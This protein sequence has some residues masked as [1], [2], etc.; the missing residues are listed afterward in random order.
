MTE[1][2]AQVSRTVNAP[3]D[4]VWDALTDPRKVGALFMGST[5]RTDF[6]KGSPITFKGEFKGKP[7]EDKGEILSVDECRRLSFSHYSGMS[8]APDAPENYHVV[9]FDLRPEGEATRVTLTQSNL[10]GGVRQADI[11]H[12]ADYEKTWSAV[13]DGLD[14]AVAH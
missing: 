1:T 5:V 6:H 12:K 10:T 4:E 2:T 14:K 9:T 7:Y 13:L 8:G 3:V 11:E